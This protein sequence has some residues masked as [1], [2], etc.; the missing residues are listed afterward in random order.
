[1]ICEDW[2]PLISYSLL[3]CSVQ[4]DLGTFSGGVHDLLWP[5]EEVIA[6]D[7][8]A[9]SLSKLNLRFALLKLASPYKHLAPRKLKSGPF[10][11]LVPLAKNAITE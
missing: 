3:G 4:F 11:A 1:L 5:L 8:T 7:S 6:N 9:N 2:L 10:A